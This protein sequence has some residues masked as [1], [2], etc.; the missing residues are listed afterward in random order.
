VSPE[1]RRQAVAGA[2]EKYKLSERRA[3]RLA[4][5]PRGTQR[6]ATIACADKDALTQA[7]IGLA[8][9]YGR[10][11]YRRITWLLKDVGWAVGTGLTFACPGCCKKSRKKTHVS[12]S[13][14]PI[15]GCVLFRLLRRL[16][17]KRALRRD[18]PLLWIGQPSRISAKRR[19]SPLR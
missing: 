6:Y 16:F 19:T 9:E 15:L 5:Q 4:I 11:D 13:F 10:F 1:R 8:S 3:C 14:A 12:K 7:I 17:G 2:R 18:A